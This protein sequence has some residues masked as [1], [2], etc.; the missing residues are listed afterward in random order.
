MLVF[1]GVTSGEATVENCPPPLGG[2]SQDLK[3]V[4]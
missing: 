1:A 2:S 4:I 3:V